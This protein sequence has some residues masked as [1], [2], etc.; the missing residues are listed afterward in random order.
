[1]YTACTHRLSEV[2]GVVLIAA[3]PKGFV[4]VAMV[5]W[6]LTFGGMAHAIVNRLR[7]PRR[8]K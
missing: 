2:T 5:A 1:M 3:I 4:Y 8:F 6:V 7:R